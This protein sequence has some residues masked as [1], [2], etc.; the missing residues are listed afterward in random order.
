MM[1][2]KGIAIVAV[3]VILALGIGVH[4]SAGEIDDL[5][6]NHEVSVANFFGINARSMAMGQTGIASSI[7][8]SGI[9]YNPA[10]LARIRRLEVAGGFSHLR[11]ENTTDYESGRYPGYVSEI[12]T[13]ERDLTKTHLDALSVTV[14]VPTYRGSLVWALGV[15]RVKNFDRTLELK[16]RDAAG[17]TNYFEEEQIETESGGIYAWSAAGAIELSPQLAVGAAFHVYSGK[18]KYSAQ[19]NLDSV[20]NA[21][22]YFVDDVSSIESDHLGVSGTVGF[23]YQA[24]P[25]LT[26]G[27]VIETPSFWNVEEESRYDAVEIYDT[28]TSDYYWE[29]EYG[30]AGSTEYNMRHPFSFGIGAALTHEQLNLALDVKY[31]D[32]SQFEYTDEFSQDLN[33]V[34]Q[35]HYKEVLAVGFGAEYVFPDQGVS[36]RAGAYYDPLPF[37]AE[38][39]EK[40]RQYFTLGIGFLID[41]VMTIDLAAVLGGYTIKYLDPLPYTEEY[42]TR[43]IYLTMGYRM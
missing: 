30:D 15:H 43:R 13:G 4:T 27:A 12:N 16:L 38:Y 11:L 41:R 1:N 14:P 32:W 29:Y 7:D 19:Y 39:I 22:S 33:A 36:L 28:L 40:D 17:A 3:A 9:I 31:T 37:P 35:E 2:R 18:A 24:S 10:C 25:Y 23:T 26:I 21:V 6:L 34:I 20:G 5:I 8:G 42:K